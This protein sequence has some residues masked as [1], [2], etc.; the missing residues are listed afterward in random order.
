M[1]DTAISVNLFV[2]LFGGVCVYVYICTCIF[3]RF[4]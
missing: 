3:E 1:G 2:R 4:V